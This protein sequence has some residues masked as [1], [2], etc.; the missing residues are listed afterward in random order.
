MDKS[1]IP[2]AEMRDVFKLQV[3]RAIGVSIVQH[4]HMHPSMELLLRHAVQWLGMK[5]SKAVQRP[6]ELDSEEK[7]HA[8]MVFLTEDEMV[9]VLSIQVLT[10]VLDGDLSTEEHKMLTRIFD[11]VPDSVGQYSELRISWTAMQFRDCVPITA[12]LLREAF[13]LDRY[14]KVRCTQPS[15]PIRWNALPRLRFASAYSYVC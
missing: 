12:Q 14:K 8:D 13:Q 6:G 7:F 1:G 4:G 9:A 3:L 10:L 5:A 11:A 2:Q 15:V